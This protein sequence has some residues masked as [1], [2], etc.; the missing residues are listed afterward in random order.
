VT[1]PPA[2]FGILNITEDSFSDGGAYLDPAAA[3]AQARRLV[4]GGADIVDIGAAAS[5]IAARPV[6]P[7][8]E[9]RRLAP[10]IDALAESGI[11]VSVDS[12]QLEVQRFAIGRGVA[13]LNDI[14]GFP[15]PSLYPA[16]AAARCRLIVMH[17]VQ[18]R[19]RAR[20]IDLSE[21]AV[22]RHIDDFFAVRIAA[23]EAAGIVRERLVIDPGMGFFLSSRP[24]ASLAV[25][26]GIARLKR[27]FGLPVLIS[28]SRK[29]FLAG[30]TGRNAAADRS[31]ASLAAEL[32]A[33]AEGV[34]YIR[35]HDPA[36]LH[37][38]LAIA[39]ALQRRRRPPCPHSGGAG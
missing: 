15:E 3:I 34:D 29:S 6:A 27:R 12:F 8:E 16:L 24:A 25:L 35:T 20:Q 22:E 39:T 32:F 1:P 38:G 13:F 2:I 5:N 9:I 4:E 30:T 11:A 28:V 36:A 17:A 37:D 18:G 31:A 19:G 7:E 23:L 14:Q 33:A 21:A 10:V 26:A